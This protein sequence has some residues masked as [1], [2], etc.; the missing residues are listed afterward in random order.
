MKR[1][2]VNK[3][4]KFC[5][6]IGINPLYLFTFLMCTFSYFIIK[7]Y[8]QNEDYEPTFFDA[9]AVILTFCLLVVTLLNILNV[10]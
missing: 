6:E 8:F 4:M 7:K 2:F 1:D 3:F 9:V 10:I 5:E